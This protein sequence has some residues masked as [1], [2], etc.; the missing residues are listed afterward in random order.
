MELSEYNRKNNVKFAISQ[1]GMF[2]FEILLL[3]RNGIP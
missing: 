1:V 2:I 3:L